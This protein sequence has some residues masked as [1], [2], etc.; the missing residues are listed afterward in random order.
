MIFLELQTTPPV[1]L[2]YC[3]I[4]VSYQDQVLGSNHLKEEPRG[5]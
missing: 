1:F 2:A 3:P 5:W 4:Y